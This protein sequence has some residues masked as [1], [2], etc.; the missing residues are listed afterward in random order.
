MGATVEDREEDDL[1]TPLPGVFIR[2]IVTNTVLP[3][4]FSRRSVTSSVT[5]RDILGSAVTFLIF[6]F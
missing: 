5:C 4:F 3:R 6:D 2:D 1:R